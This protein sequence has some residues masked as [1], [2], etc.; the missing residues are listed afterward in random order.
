MNTLRKRRGFTLIELLVVIAI[1]G[2]LVGLLLPAVQSAR[3][4]GRRTACLNNMRQIGLAM[5]AYEG[6]KSSLPGWRNKLTGQLDVSWPTV[7]LP[8][9]ERKDIF[10]EWNTYVPAATNPADINYSLS[11]IPAKKLQPVVETFM[12]P[13]SP[14]NTLEKGSISYAMNGGS[15]L[16]AVFPL[17]NGSVT[18]YRGDGVGLDRI[19]GNQT[20]NHR[21]PKKDI[22]LDIITTGDGT[23]NT[24]LLA[25]KCGENVSQINLF[26]RQTQMFHSETPLIAT[27]WSL[28]SGSPKVVLLPAANS[29]PQTNVI[30]Q[31]SEPY[32][33]PSSFHPGGCN[34][35]FADAHTA[36]LQESVQPTVYCQLMTSNTDVQNPPNNSYTTSSRVRNWGLPPLNSNS[37]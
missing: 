36:F 18:Q 24:L 21:Y 12:C 19:G 29:M 32:R 30:N 15:G 11:D 23:A 1:I 7:I 2:I 10:N 33:Y 4:A 8:D 35:V 28:N 34:I 26:D 25:E 27:A 31:I 17:I 37:Y 9:L 5:H 13:S 20:D 6:K 14:P 16:E 3:E 22:N